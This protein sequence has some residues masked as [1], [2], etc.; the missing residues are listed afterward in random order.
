M[1]HKKAGTAKSGFIHAGRMTIGHRPSQ[2]VDVRMP[3]KQGFFLTA[4]LE[5]RIIPEQ[6]LRASHGNSRPDHLPG[7]GRTADGGGAPLT[8]RCGCRPFSNQQP[9]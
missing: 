2:K 3:L 6:I 1:R 4:F 9:S 7:Y 5:M 8:G